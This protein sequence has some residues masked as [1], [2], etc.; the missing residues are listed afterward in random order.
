LG[1]WGDYET[2]KTLDRE[3]H[4]GSRLGASRSER[5]HVFALQLPDVPALW[6]SSLLRIVS[7]KVNPGT[8]DFT[9]WNAVEPISAPAASE[10]VKIPEQS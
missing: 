6:W 3:H 8:L 9:E 5:R 10:V 4:G 1:Y 2:Q 7:V